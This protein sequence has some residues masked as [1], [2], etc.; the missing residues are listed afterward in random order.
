MTKRRNPRP[1]TLTRSEALQ[2]LGLDF[3]AT[4][5]QIRSAFRAAAKQ[6][7]PDV[8]GDAEMF[9]RITEAYDVLKGVVQAAPE[10]APRPSPTTRPAEPGVE[11]IRASDLAAALRQVIALA[12]LHPHRLYHSVRVRI[13]SRTG[14]YEVDLEDLLFDA[15]TGRDIL[16]GPAPLPPRSA[17]DEE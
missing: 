17:W 4:E 7:H 14:P 3:S 12:H 1:S 10:A 13:I 11:E 15:G 2:L 9:K 16:S 8:G 6:H 5:S